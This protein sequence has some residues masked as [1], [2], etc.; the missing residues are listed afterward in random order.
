[1]RTVY[2]RLFAAE[3]GVSHLE[4]VAAELLP[5]FAAP[6]AEPAHTAP[7]AG[8]DLED[9]ARVIGAL[10]TSMPTGCGLPFV[11]Q[12]DYERLVSP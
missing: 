7:G 1:M 6:P 12:R 3:D 9:A 4:D 5:G 11:R 2:T 8:A 10:V